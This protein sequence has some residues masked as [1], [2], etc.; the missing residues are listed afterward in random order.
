MRVR[1]VSVYT[2]RG[3]RQVVLAAAVAVGLLWMGEAGA[4]GGGLGFAAAH[5][6]A[7]L[8]VAR[9]A[10]R[11]VAPD[12]GRR[13]ATVAGRPVAPVGGRRLATVA[14]R[15]VAMVGG[16]PVA[17]AAERSMAPAGQGRLIARDS[18]P[19]HT[20]GARIVNR[21]GRPVHLAAVN[22]YGGESVDFAPGG[23]QL[24]P[25]KQ[26]VSEIRRL[27]FNA[28]RLPYSNQMVEQ[29]PVVP[30]YAV[31]ANPELEGLHAMQ[32]YER[33]VHALTGQGIAVVLDDHNSNAE[34]CCSATDGNTLWY[35]SRY[36]QRAW[37]SD[38]KE[39]AA[40]FRNDP[41]VI[42][43]DLRNEPRGAATWGGPSSTNWPAAA[44]LG[45]DAVLSVNRHLLV[46]VE[47]ISYAGDLSGV[48]HLP[49]VLDVPHHLV[50][51]AHD[52]AW[53]E[54]GF[55]S[56]KQWYEQVYPKWAY[57]VTGP[58]PQ[59]L[60]V[61]EFGTCDTAASCV[62]DSTS[63]SNGFWFHILTTFLQRYDVN[64]CY[65]PINGT[66]STGR[67]RTYGAPE[68][69]GVLNAKWDGPALPALT[70]RLAQIERS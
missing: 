34:W 57:L 14:G 39:M 5:G 68:T 63:G 40:T 56:Y 64:W 42:G 36:P 10:G 62:S 29:D 11:P 6:A 31:A 65:W 45:G 2:A 1:L 4:G 59:P 26:I 49:V 52:Y 22:W 66:Q 8:R 58:K 53:Y 35:N 9:V 13:V 54:P 24:Q 61:G 3:W 70:R 47:G 12:A 55:S 41:L 18:L 7:G 37:L 19:L 21:F 33:V 43:A 20:A 60:W 27:G 51:E 50:Y 15:P 46:F 23:L 28:V 25:L 16:R 30:G 67:S 17:P 69:Y 38:W 32:V 48:K 44:E